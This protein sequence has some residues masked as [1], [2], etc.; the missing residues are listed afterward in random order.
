MSLQ[1][2]ENK[3]GSQGGLLHIDTT[4]VGTDADTSEKVLNT[5]TLPANSLD[6]DG[7]G[8]RVRA[9][10]SVAANANNKTVKIEFGGV[11]MVIA[12]VVGWNGIDWLFEAEIFRTG[13]GAQICVGEYTAD[14]INAQIQR[15]TPSSD[16]TTALD[17]ELI[18]LNATAA[19]NDIVCNGMTVELVSQGGS[20]PAPAGDR[21]LEV[22]TTNYPTTG[23]SEETLASITLPANT[24]SRDGMAVEITAWGSLAGNTNSK[25][26]KI[27]FGGTVVASHTTS[28]DSLNWNMKTVV[29]RTG[30]A[31][32]KGAGLA[33][34]YLT[35]P[36]VLN[37]AVTHDLTTDCPIIFTGET[38]TA[39]GDITLRGFS[40]KLINY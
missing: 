35:V 32:Q 29:T 10:G 33:F 17:V 22:D 14:A 16:E 39:S 24:L 2:F 20:V 37:A 6:M 5:Y 18:G 9:W 34:E 8:I 21:L 12:G 3:S 25:V 30:A 27:K 4:A 40:V 28:G 1:V 23:T 31:T 36:S 15:S 7:K 38:P 13:V 11:Q 19:A 26:R